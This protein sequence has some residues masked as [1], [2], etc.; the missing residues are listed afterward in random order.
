MHGA[1]I[2][3]ISAQQ[4]KLSNNDKNTGL[5]LLKTNAAI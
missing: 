2:K 5:K 3:I 1:A 4:E